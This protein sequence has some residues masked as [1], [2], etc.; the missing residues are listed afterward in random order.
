M[1]EYLPFYK[2]TFIPLDNEK[3]NNSKNNFSQELE[4]HSKKIFNAKFALATSSS[5]NALHLAL[6]A[7][8]IKRGD[9]IICSVNSFSTTP[10]AIRHFDAEPIFVDCDSKTYLIDIDKLEDTLEQ[11]TNKKLRAVILNS[12]DGAMV[13]FKRVAQ[14][15]KK[16]N[17]KILFDATDSMCSK[18][19]DENISVFIDAIVL[20]F[21]P[22]IHKDIISG[23]ILLLNNEELHDRA[24]ML[25][26]NGVINQLQKTTTQ[27]NY[28]Y[29]I[30][31]IG[32]DYRINEISAFISMQR[33][34]KLQNELQRKHDIA[35]RYK[36]EL[37][38][39][40]HISIASDINQHC[41]T[42]FFIEVD[43]NRDHFARELFSEGVEI[44]LHY[45]PLHLSEYYRNKYSLK[46]FDFPNALSVYQKTMVLPLYS[47]MSDEDVK[48]VIK[49]VKDVASRYMK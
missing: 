35:S 47:S 22:N 48:K 34:N 32:Y 18:F 7:F 36:K 10:Q 28:A 41:V 25:R 29:D 4:E 33:L 16:Y 49:S 11:N 43:K 21:T 45:V 44:A 17:V 14:L 6:C 46:V 38:N 15:A 30:Q 1:K 39:T 31:D 27:T 5:A 26:N 37:D 2:P 24:V 23:A 8:D 42:N 9:K 19:D 3:L 12:L 13:D 40:E 20:S